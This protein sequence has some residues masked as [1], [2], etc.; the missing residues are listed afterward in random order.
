VIKDPGAYHICYCHSPLR[1]IWDQRTIY[2]KQLPRLVRPFAQGYAAHLRRSDQGSAMRVDQFVANSKFVAQRIQSYYRRDAV[3]IHPPVNVDAF[4]PDPAVE[5][6]YLLAGQLRAYKGAALAIEACARLGRPLVIMGG[7]ENAELR[8]LA[9]PNVKFIGRVSDQEFKRI[10][11]RCR[12]LL[13]PGVEDFGIIPVEA[14]ASGRPVIARAK[15][16]AVET[17]SDG[18]TGIL[19]DDPSVD[20]LEKAILSFEAEER[21]FRPE[22]CVA[23]AQRFSQ[24]AFLNA[25][26]KLLP[27]GARMPA[28]VRSLAS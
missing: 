10:L 26:S 28:E 6:Y 24:A 13:F 27:A 16:G 3:V 8:R 7:G 17:V 14:M 11:A 20:G 23:H 1:Y 2:M 18:V 5:D 21:H 4:G 15:G 9:G 25:F 19:Y 22:N 12:A